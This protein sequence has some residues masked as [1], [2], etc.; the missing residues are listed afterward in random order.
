MTDEK[1][2]KIQKNEFN[3]N[4]N[5]IKTSRSKKTEDTQKK[6]IWVQ[7][8]L[9]P[10]WARILIV[11]LLLIIAIITGAMVGYGVLGDGVP[12][13]V[14]KKETWTHILDIIRGEQS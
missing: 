12:S 2:N 1:Q 11:L 14:L 7:M 4:T 9:I 10:I 13:D 3:S 6:T 5:P 8:N